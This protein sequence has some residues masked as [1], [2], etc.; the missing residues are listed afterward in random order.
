MHRV[1][2]AAALLRTAGK[3]GVQVQEQVL[4]FLEGFGR[5]V[6]RKEDVYLLVAELVRSKT[7]AVAAYMKWLIA[8]GSLYGFDSMHKVGPP[9]RVCGHKADD[10]CRII[11][12]M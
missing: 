6:G 1:Y 5:V 12:A 3:T 4:V 10:G 7:F 8:R 11:L 9:T 2:I